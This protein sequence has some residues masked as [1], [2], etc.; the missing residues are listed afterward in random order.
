MLLFMILGLYDT[1]RQLLD[2]T[3]IHQDGIV[4][5]IHMQ[6]LYRDESDR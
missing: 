5:D 4:L 2:V 3:K 6:P 1:I